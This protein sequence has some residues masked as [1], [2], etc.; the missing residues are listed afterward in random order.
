MV[1]LNV[2]VCFQGIRR[3]KSGQA[4]SCLDLWTS[5]ARLLPSNQPKLAPIS[6]QALGPR[7]RLQTP[8]REATGQ[9]QSDMFPSETPGWPTQLPS[10]LEL[11]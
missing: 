8:G 7:V 1:W 2:L 5:G 11:P 3:F 10:M 4:S 9:Q 6:Q